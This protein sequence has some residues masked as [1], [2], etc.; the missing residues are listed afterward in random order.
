MVILQVGIW[1]ILSLSLPLWE[2]LEALKQMSLN[3]FVSLNKRELCSLFFLLLL[4]PSPF[5]L[6]VPFNLCLFLEQESTPPPRL[7]CVGI[8][9]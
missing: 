4:F 6:F 3:H 8:L 9:Q 5:S 2:A 1:P 7:V